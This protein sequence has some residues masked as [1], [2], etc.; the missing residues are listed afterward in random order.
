MN[1]R[2]IVVYHVAPSGIREWV[3]CAMTERDARDE[4][5]RWRTNH[6]V[7]SGSAYLQHRRYYH[8]RWIDAGWWKATCHVAI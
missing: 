6:T 3:T 7:H 2:N 4:Y 1:I 8:T 5:Q